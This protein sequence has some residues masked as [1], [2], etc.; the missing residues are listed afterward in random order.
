MH[1]A[2]GKRSIKITRAAAASLAHARRPHG[3]REGTPRRGNEVPAPG[4]DAC[5]IKGRVYTGSSRQQ[6]FLGI[7]DSGRG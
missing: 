1:K 6:L 4:D 5:L 7:V 2:S 3:G